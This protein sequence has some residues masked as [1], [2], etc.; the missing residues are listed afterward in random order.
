[1][2]I[3]LTFSLGIYL[4]I[5]IVFF[6]ILFAYHVPFVYLFCRVW[7]ELYNLKKIASRWLQ[8]CNNLLNYLICSYLHFQVELLLKTNFVLKWYVRY[9]LENIL[10]LCKVCLLLNHSCSISNDNG[11]WTQVTML[12]DTC[13]GKSSLF[14]PV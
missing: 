12:G 3:F 5:G 4:C 11:L 10:R 7:R 14:Y 9:F 8:K 6:L 13:D 1:M 2:H